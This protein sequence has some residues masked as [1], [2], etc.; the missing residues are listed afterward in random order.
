MTTAPSELY[1]LAEWHGIQLKYVDYRGRER[2]AT[3]ESLRAVLNCLGVP[4]NHWSESRDL[5][6][7]AHVEAARQL[8]EP[9]S[10]IRDSSQDAVRVR[11]AEASGDRELTC[12]LALEDGTVQSWTVKPEQ[13]LAQH[14]HQ[15]EGYTYREARLR[16]GRGLPHGYHRLEV[17]AGEQRQSALVLVAP[18]AAFVLAD[19]KARRWGVFLPLYALHSRASWGAG[20]FGDLSALNDWVAA[21]GGSLV[22]TLPLL[23]S[24]FDEPGDESPYRPVSR[25]FWNEF[26]LDLNQ[27][28]ELSA[29]EEARTL[30]QS[31]QLAFERER[32]R[33][34]ETVDYRQQMEL[35]RRILHA[36]VATAFAGGSSRRQQLESWMQRNPEVQRYARFRAAID[37]HGRPWTNWP[38]RLRA[39]DIASGDYDEPAFRY[40]VYVQFLVAEQLT[41]LSQHSQSSR[42]AWYLD[43]PLG[44]HP[45]GFDVWR[46]RETFAT[47]ASGGAPPDGFF[48][49]GQ[50]WD[51][52][53]LHPARL[54]TLGY[55]YFLSVLRAQLTYAKVLRIDHVMGLHRLFWIPRGMEADQGVYVRYAAEELYAVLVIE[56]QRARARIIG[57]DLG[58]VPPE[59]G[60]AMD[61][62]KIGRLYVVQYECRPNSDWA[63]ADPGANSV[64]GLNTHDMPPF[65]AFWQGV[66]IDDRVDLKLMTPQEALAERSHR[67][68]TRQAL[69]EFLRRRGLLPD[70]DESPA[71][72]LEACLAFLGQSAAEVVLVNLEDLWGET[73]P[74]NTPGTVS[75]RINWRRKSRL[76]LESICRDPFVDRVLRRV[77]AA[78]GRA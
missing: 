9:V 59:T 14:S 18:D 67:Q 42:L 17:V 64:A 2:C 56:S 58:T 75:E 66:D 21:R 19:Q 31:G 70:A 1:E 50:F 33:Q 45:D 72:V 32:L 27:I 4:L 51:F 23:A 38:D 34:S 40:H 35:K 30:L 26:F 16:I 49:K 48:T 54:R 24:F 77:A 25:L 63:L 60:I 13:L 62:H 7:A 20:D 10:V 39:G 71:A 29:C 37:R 74:Q 57:E 11:I 55:E 73:L 78:R 6:R 12:R 36:L 46:Y 61:R 76:T 44:V 3:P 15:C 43:L 28:P 65:A 5:L 52:L 69:V 53:P 22:A 8:L 41:Q 47:G 68:A